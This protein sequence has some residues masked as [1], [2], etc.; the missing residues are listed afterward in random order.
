MKTKWRLAASIGVPVVVGG[1]LGT[2]ATKNAKG[3]YQSLQKPSFSPPSWVFP[4]TWTTLY[5][6]MGIA[7]YQFDKQNK[8]DTLQRRVNTAYGTQLGLNY[9][10]PFLFF[11][12][13][14]RGTAFIEATLLWSAVTLNTYYF[15]KRS[16]LACSLMIPYISWL[17]YAL[18][19]NY[20][21]WQLNKN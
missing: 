2:I 11:R 4:V 10:W 13:N 9:L 8:T 18:R 20:R 17:T 15:N 7:K 14:M 16:K 5:T 1:I 12:W 3:E 19:L 21:T 6:T